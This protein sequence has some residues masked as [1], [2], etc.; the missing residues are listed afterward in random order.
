[1]AWYRYID[2]IMILWGG[3]TTLLEEYLEYNLGNTF[4]LKFTMTYNSSAVTFLDLTIKK[5]TDGSLQTELFR[6][7]IAGVTPFWRPL[8]SILNH[9][10]QLFP[11]D[12]ISE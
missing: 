1:M 2:D 5:D 12:S 4:N 6:K 9:Y 8:A 7:P 10:W 3:S 11:L